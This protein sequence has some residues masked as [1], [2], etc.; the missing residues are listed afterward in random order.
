MPLVFLVVGLL[1]GEDGPGGIMSDDHDTPFL[2]GSVAL[3]LILLAGGLRRRSAAFRAAA[4]R[5]R[6]G[7][8]ADHPRRP[9]LA[10]NA[11]ATRLVLDYRAD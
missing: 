9:A 1:A 7:A 10:E 2:V 5:E 3:A 8:R 6:N 4:A 11:V